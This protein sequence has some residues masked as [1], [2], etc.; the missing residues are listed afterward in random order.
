MTYDTEEFNAYFRLFELRSYTP[1]GCEDWLLFRSPESTRLLRE[2]AASLGGKI[3]VSHFGIA[4]DLLRNSGEITQLRQPK[5]VEIE[6]PEL[7]VEQYR[8]MPTRAFV[9]KYRND[10][11]FKSQ[12]DSLVQRGLI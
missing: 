10:K 3:S 6:E 5:P 7:T 8:A 4:F 9:M 2:K 12:V 11:L 1:E